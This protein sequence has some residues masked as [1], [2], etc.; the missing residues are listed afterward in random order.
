V[1]SSGDPVAGQD[2][3]LELTDMGDGTYEGNVDHDLVVSNRDKLRARVVSSKGAA[4][5]FAEPT[6][7][8]VTDGK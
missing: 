7:K 3:P 8:V 2:W 1:D 5:G 4:R 6:I